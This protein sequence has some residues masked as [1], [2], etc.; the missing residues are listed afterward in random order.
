[1]VLRAGL[2]HSFVGAHKNIVELKLNCRTVKQNQ[3]VVRV[4]GISVQTWIYRFALT[5]TRI[6]IL[7][8]ARKRMFKNR[9]IDCFNN[10]D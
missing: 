3:I 10:V 6:Y 9:P 4:R 7:V 1:M 8:S 5:C 2:K